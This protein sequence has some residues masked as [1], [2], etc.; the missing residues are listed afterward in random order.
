MYETL[1]TVWREL[2]GPGGD[3]EVETL[4]VRGFPMRTF[5]TAAPSLPPAELKHITKRRKRN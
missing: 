2:T 4:E 5:K 1:K 3:F